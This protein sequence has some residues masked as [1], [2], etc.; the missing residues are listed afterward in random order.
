MRTKRTVQVKGSASKAVIRGQAK[1]NCSD[2]C[3]FLE[4]SKG[5]GLRKVVQATQRWGDPLRALVSLSLQ[6]LHLA[7]ELLYLA[8]GSGALR[9]QLLDLAVQLGAPL[10]RRDL[11]HGLLPHLV[12]LV[13][14]AVHLIPAPAMRA[15]EVTDAAFPLQCVGHCTSALVAPY[16]KLIASIAS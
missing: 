16:G 15:D 6:R 5:A 13:C 12:P 1:T 3:W 4:L 11:A 8:V 9:L 10:G 7:L 14:G 2:A